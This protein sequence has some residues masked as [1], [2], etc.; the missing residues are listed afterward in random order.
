MDAS[1]HKV[2][3]SDTLEALKTFDV[4]D[5]DIWLI[6]YPKAGTTWT[7]EIINRIQQAG[8]REYVV[9][10]NSLLFY[11]EFSLPGRKP[12]D[13]EFADKTS[14]RI[15][16]THLPGECLPSQLL[17]KNVKVIY[18]SRNP[19]DVAVSFFHHHKVDPFIK[20]YPEW[21]QFYEDFIKG[22]VPYGSWGS[23]VIYW[24]N[25]RE[26]K[27]VLFLTY[28]DMKKDLRRNVKL[29][30]DF[31]GKKLSDESISG[32]TEECTFQNM[33][34][35]NL[36]KKMI[37]NVFKA[38]H[39]QSPFVRQGKVSGWKEYFTVAQNDD[40]D[41]RVYPEWIGDSKIQV[42]FQ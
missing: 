14:P 8:N 40:F 34:K 24:W 28:E 37:E 25:R 31:L 10:E 20:D 36:H 1:L 38:D 42:E 13:E 22:E 35:Q 4:R 6:T 17:Q 27:N 5:D 33:K 7:A 15:F 3:N 11:P 16:V 9:A 39:S 21:S 12:V 26:Q 41:Q 32:I 2:I 18:V 19:K 30:A 29:V 23:H